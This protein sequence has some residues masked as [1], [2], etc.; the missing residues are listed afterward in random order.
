[1]INNN[2]FILGQTY[3]LTLPFR[4]LKYEIKSKKEKTELAKGNDKSICFATS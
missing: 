1:M 3:S 4:M 2:V